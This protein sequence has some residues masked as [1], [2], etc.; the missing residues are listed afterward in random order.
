VA[1]NRFDIDTIPAATATPPSLPSCIAKGNASTV[2][3]QPLV[4]NIED[5]QITYGLEIPD[6]QNAKLWAGY[7]RADLNSSLIPTRRL[8]RIYPQNAGESRHGSTWP[9]V[10]ARMPVSVR[11]PRALTS[12]VPALWKK[13]PPP[14]DLR[15]RARTPPQSCCE[16]GR[17]CVP[18]PYESKPSN[19]HPTQ[20]RGKP[21]RHSRLRTPQ[22]GAVTEACA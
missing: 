20:R 3:T 8:G 1:N 10:R 2:Q 18:T 4:E 13:P 11:Q 22:H 9:T 14:D 15:L 5:M 12:T 6:D 16:I 17:N 19:L 7:L 21:R